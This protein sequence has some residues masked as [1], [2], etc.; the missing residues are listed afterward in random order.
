MRFGAYIFYMNLNGLSAGKRANIVKI[1]LERGLKTRLAGFGITEGAEV[2]FLMRAPLGD[3][4]LV[5]VCG[6]EVIL[7]TEEAS[8]VT[9]E[10][11]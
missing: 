7:R 4:I 9:V 3:P 5:G 11:L 2:V 6:S 10:E 1:E 8:A